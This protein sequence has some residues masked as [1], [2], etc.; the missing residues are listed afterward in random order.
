MNATALRIRRVYLILLL[1]HTLAASLIWGINTL[2]LL[3]AGLSNTEAFAA[4]A[5][6]TAG[7]VIFEVPTGV[8]ADTRGRRTSY[9]LG[10]IT[11][12]ASTVLYLLM[13]RISAPLWAWAIA[14]ALLGLGF[15]F[16]SGAVQAWLVDALTASGYFREGGKLEAVLAKG[17]I[18]EGAAML[19]GSVAG[20][21]IA[22]A[23]NLGVPYMIRASIL[24][25]SFV[26][27]F[28]LMR[29]E[30]FT[31]NLGK[32][33]IDEVR[34][35]LRNS[36]AHGFGNPPVRWIM[37]ETVFTG[38]VMA[39]AFYAM[40]PYLLELYGNPHA[41]SVAGL[42]AAIVAGAQI[43]GGLIVPYAG[44][45][46]ARRTSVLLCG[47]ALNTAVLLGIGVIP[48]F[49]VAV[50]LLVLWG[51]MY[52][53]IT[54]VRQAYLNSL[55][56]ARE[57]ATVLSFDSLLASS[58]AAVSQPILGKT[59]DVWGYPASYIGCAAIQ[60]LSLPFIW[61]AGRERAA[62]DAMDAAA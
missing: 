33:P 52:S 61:F 26:C 25:L 58:G 8:V 15:T 28:V 10:T 54:P 9:L 49:W 2:F 31:P 21:V 62:A 57:R 35:V 45:L 22:Q 39:Y 38:G 34:S 44:R 37:L 4:N 29:D 20:G 59:A 5:F 3:D 40:Q 47:T 27:A 42:A 12:A 53:A 43:A 7:Q 30:G 18:V 41:Y 13:W 46:F 23:T 36:I 16:F 17:E 55:I 11:L 50:S 56:A 60:V 32:R 14:S 24:V 19:V 1:L 51:L 6:F 48:Q